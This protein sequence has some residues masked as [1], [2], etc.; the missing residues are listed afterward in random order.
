MTFLRRVLLQKGQDIFRHIL[1]DFGAE[2]TPFQ[3]G[4]ILCFVQFVLLHDSVEMHAHENLWHLTHEVVQ[5]IIQA[6]QHVD[7][8]LVVVEPQRHARMLFIAENW[9][10][11]AD[12]HPNVLEIPQQVPRE[13]QVVVAGT[14][15]I[16][17][18]G[19]IVAQVGH[20]QVV[21]VGLLV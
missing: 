13:A 8:L 9:H 1:H 16:V 2:F 21:V 15:Q 14:R 7:G 10:I 6:G 18:D 5:P 17:V 12:Q 4:Q 11:R 19:L 20:D 3:I